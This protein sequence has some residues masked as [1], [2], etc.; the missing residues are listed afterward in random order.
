MSS[1]LLCS[2]LAEG[3]QNYIFLAKDI[4]NGQNYAI[5]A[6][7]SEV[8]KNYSQMLKREYAIMTE[9]LHGLDCII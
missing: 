1:L 9:N 5:K 3:G 4:A 6:S 7:K 8:N 2:K